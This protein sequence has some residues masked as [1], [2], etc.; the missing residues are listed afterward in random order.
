MIDQSDV[1]I[2]AW[3][4]R[5][6]KHGMST[7]TIGSGVRVHH[8]KTGMVIVCNKSDRQHVNKDTALALLQM[9]LDEVVE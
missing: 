9:A 4:D 7:G 8:L 6:T 2:S 5:R 1:I 3:P